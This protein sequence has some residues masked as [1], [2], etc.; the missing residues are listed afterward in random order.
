MNERIRQLAKQATN[1]VEIVNPDTSITHHR[2]FFDQ[3]KFAELL[4]RECDRYARGAW[5]HGP[6]L[7]RDLLIHF[8]FE[9]LTDTE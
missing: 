9:K 2:E 6:L 7:G 8:G 1:S 5:E 4:V 3:E